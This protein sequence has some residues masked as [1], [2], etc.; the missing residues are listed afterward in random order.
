MKTDINNKI[1][2]LRSETSLSYS[3]AKLNKLS[4]YQN[5]KQKQ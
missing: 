5:I 2:L 1:R 3:S 4:Y